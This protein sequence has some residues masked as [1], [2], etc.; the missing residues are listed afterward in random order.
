MLFL[1]HSEISTHGSL[2][3]LSAQ[4]DLVESEKSDIVRDIDGVSIS[5]S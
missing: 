1:G 5:N 3:A 4:R 2:G